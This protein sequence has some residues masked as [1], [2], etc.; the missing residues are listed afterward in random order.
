MSALLNKARGEVSLVVD[1]RARRLCLTLGA[2]AELE[3]AFDCHGFAELGAR[4]STLSAADAL[5]V[6]AALSAGGGEAISSAA[7]SAA[8]IDPRE[9]IEAIGAAFRD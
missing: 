2:L 7:L 6:I 1:G 8:R 9:A 5:L 3:G 4:L